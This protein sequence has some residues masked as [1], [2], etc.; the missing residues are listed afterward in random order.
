[1]EARTITVIPKKTVQT[2]D[3]ETGET[4][5]KRVCAYA[6][7]STDL[8]DQKNSFNA[9][10]EYYKDYIQKNPEWEFV[11]LY[12]DEGISGTSIKNRKGFQQMIHDAMNGQ[13]DLILT[14]SISRFARNTV[15]CLQKVR[16]LRS[17]GVIV[18]FEKF[19]AKVVI[20]I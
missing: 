20:F 4:R 6:R 14:K 10:T 12:S 19:T 1:M 7:V 18:Y 11:K 17:K 5:K 15:D 2:F 3:I 16:D 13:I 9:Q 8:E